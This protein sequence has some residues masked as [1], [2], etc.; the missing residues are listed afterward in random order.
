MQISNY[1]LLKLEMLGNERDGMNSIRL[2]TINLFAL[3]LKNI[4][5]Y[6]QSINIINLHK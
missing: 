4:K 5:Y 6:L 2:N 3:P 1:F